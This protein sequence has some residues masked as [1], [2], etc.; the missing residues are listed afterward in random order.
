MRT[1]NIEERLGQ[2]PSRWGNL[3]PNDFAYGSTTLYNCIVAQHKLADVVLPF[4]QARYLL[5]ENATQ[6]EDDVKMLLF[7]R[8]TLLQSSMMTYALCIDLSWQ[9]IYF[10]YVAESDVKLITDLNYYEGILRNC[11][12]NKLIKELKKS[13]L[14][15]ANDVLLHLKIYRDK[16]LWKKI[17]D[18]NKYIKHRGRFNITGLMINENR[19]MFSVN[20]VVPHLLIRRE[21]DVDEWTENLIEFNKDFSAY[22][23][24]I[25]EFILLECGKNLTASP[26]TILNNLSKL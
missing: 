17:D 19:M 24:K 6:C 26:I 12:Y 1:I 2:I 11:N 14:S 8:A 21:F 5:I 18:T 15:S 16:E 3:E 9:A 10:M 7:K 4:S 20:N 13:K 23:N 25:I 22:F